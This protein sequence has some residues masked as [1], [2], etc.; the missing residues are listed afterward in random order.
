LFIMWTDSDRPQGA[1]AAD[2][3]TPEEHAAE[4]AKLEAE[5]RAMCAREAAVN[6]QRAAEL[7]ASY[8]AAIA[9]VR[10]IAERLRKDPEFAQ[11]VDP[12]HVFVASCSAPESEWD[13]LARMGGAPSCSVR[14]ELPDPRAATAYPLCVLL[15]P[16]APEAD[17]N[18]WR[19][20]VEVRFADPRQ[21]SLLN[22]GGYDRLRSGA[23][24][25]EADGPIV[26]ALSRAGLGRCRPSYPPHGRESR[27]GAQQG[28]RK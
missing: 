4:R 12:A 7:K 25:P 27:P 5:R 2:L 17:A 9:A 22:V 19:C 26:A 21:L 11:R 13:R 20:V 16:V 6:A 18:N 10:R 28:W 3:S 24:V 15:V 23:R 1:L 8:E 14:D